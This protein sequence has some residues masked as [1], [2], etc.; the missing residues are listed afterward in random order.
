MGAPRPKISFCLNKIIHFDLFLRSTGIKT[1]KSNTIEFELSLITIAHSRQNL[2]P[3]IGEC[4]GGPQS[5][6]PMENVAE[7]PRKVT[8]TAFSFK[9]SFGRVIFGRLLL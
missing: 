2:P 3:M 5:P 9:D 8:L 7:L 1:S 6:I 4:N